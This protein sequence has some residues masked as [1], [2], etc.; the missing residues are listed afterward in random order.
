MR[1]YHSSPA[2]VECPNIVYSRDYLDFGKGFYVATLKHQAEQYAQRFILRGSR[3]FL[4]EYELAENRI[5]SFSTKRFERYDE[6]W[7]DFVMACRSGLDKS[8]WDVV[9]GGIAND[10]V[11]RTV[12]LFFAGDLSKADALKRLAFEKPND[13]ICLRS[14]KAIDELLTFVGSLEVL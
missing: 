4:N 8:S 12:D 14:Q 3:A 1:V 6:E 10:K 13:Q 9:L 5:G 7:L 2:M 11:F